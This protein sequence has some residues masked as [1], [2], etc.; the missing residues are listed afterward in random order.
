[1]LGQVHPPDKSRPAV[2]AARELKE[3]ANAALE[4][5]QGRGLPRSPPAVSRERSVPG[6]SAHPEAEMDDDDAVSSDWGKQRII[7]GF[8][9]CGSR[10]REKIHP[11]G[12]DAE[13]M[14]LAVNRPPLVPVGPCQLIYCHRLRRRVATAVP[15]DVRRVDA[16]ERPPHPVQPRQ[17]LVEHVPRERV[18]Y[19]HYPA[20]QRSGLQIRER[21]PDGL[22]LKQSLRTPPRSATRCAMCRA[23]RSSY[24]AP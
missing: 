20:P 9:S 21:A 3:D 15:D 12:E 1:M 4:G 11:A 5:G 16:P 18:P 13:V 8:G 2:L 24:T 22:E 19:Q 6:K 14:P 10:G 7:K 23:A 17:K